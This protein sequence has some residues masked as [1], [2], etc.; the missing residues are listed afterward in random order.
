MRNRPRRQLSGRGSF[1]R[2][3]RRQALGRGNMRFTLSL[4]RREALFPA[5]F[6]DQGAWAGKTRPYAAPMRRGIVFFHQN[7][8]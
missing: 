5:R 1:P 6:R 3:N 4:R 2:P 7:R 8:H